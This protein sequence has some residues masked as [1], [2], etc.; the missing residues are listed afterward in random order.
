MAR[1]LI[2]LDAG[3]TTWRRYL[4]NILANSSAELVA[5]GRQDGGADGAGGK[6]RAAPRAG[7][8]RS[9][10]HDWQREL[11]Y[12]LVE[13]GTLF[14]SARSRTEQA[15]APFREAVAHRAPADRDRYRQRHLE[16]RAAPPLPPVVELLVS[17]GNGEEAIAVLQET[18]ALWR[19]AIAINPGDL[20]QHFELGWLANYLGNAFHQLHRNAEALATYTEALEAMRRFVAANPTDEEGQKT[21]ALILGNYARGLLRQAASPTRSR[22]YARASAYGATWWRRSIRARRA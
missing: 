17:L 3:N 16:E 9:R 4:S 6:P 12:I 7:R 21:L 8:A 14:A 13:I 1:R 18:L 2:A 11:S 10:Q 15:L 19:Q 22:P 5:L 20:T